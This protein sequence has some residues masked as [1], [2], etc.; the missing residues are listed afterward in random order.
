MG[1][2]RWSLG[3]RFART[4]FCLRKTTGSRSLFFHQVKTR[5]SAGHNLAEREG[6]SLARRFAR[7]LLGFKSPSLQEANSSPFRMSCFLLAE[8]EGFEPS[9]ELSPL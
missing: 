9:Q 5:L 2:E 4:L 7:T 6:W 1:I 8:R 3:Q